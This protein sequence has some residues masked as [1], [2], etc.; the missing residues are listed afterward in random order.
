MK[1]DNSIQPQIDTPEML[2][3]KNGKLDIL[4]FV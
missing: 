1:K 3:V 2:W 4:E